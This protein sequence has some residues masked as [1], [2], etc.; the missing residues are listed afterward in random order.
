MT[1]KS[2]KK[3]KTRKAKRAPARRHP[4]SRKVF[5]DLLTD[6]EQ[7]AARQL[8]VA[9][10][11]LSLVETND[12]MPREELMIRTAMGQALAQ[13]AEGMRDLSGFAEIVCEDRTVR[14]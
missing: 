8:L 14:S 3:P 10:S 4:L 5:Q 6:L 9:E 1:T 11:L 7:R 2:A 12:E 13:H